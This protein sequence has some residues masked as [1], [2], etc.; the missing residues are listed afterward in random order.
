MFN[1]SVNNSFNKLSEKSNHFAILFQ[2]YAL[3]YSCIY[4]PIDK[5]FVT[6]DLRLK[7]SSR[8]SRKHFDY[9]YQ[10]STRVNLT[11]GVLKASLRTPFPSLS[12][13]GVRVTTVNIAI[14]V[15]FY[16]DLTLKKYPKKFTISF[17]FF[18]NRTKR[19]F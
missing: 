18:R 13:G 15:S 11:K 5:W 19:R 10:L 3:K 6:G 9:E 7:P 8:K 17:N 1:S 16:C 4:E 14:S 12:R 2:K